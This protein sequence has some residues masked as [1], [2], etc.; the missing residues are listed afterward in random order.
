MSDSRVKYERI[1]SAAVLTINR[2]ERR[3]AID[4]ETAALLEQRFE[5]FC[6]DDT[7]L[8]LIVAG[9]GGQAFCAGADLK[10]VETLIPRLEGVGGP[11]GFSRLHSPKP[12]IAAVSG[13][14][15][16]GGFELALWCDIRIA[17]AESK[18]GFTERRFGVPLV[19][20]G[21]QRLPRVVGAGVAL[22]LTLSGRVVD[23]EEAHRIGLANELVAEGQHLTRALEY[24]EM[25]ATFPRRTM[26]AD[27][28]ALY[29]G[30]DLPLDEGLAFEARSGA[31]TL[32]DAAA[33]AARFASGEGRSANPL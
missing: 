4:G 31:A 19:D 7:A 15:L 2:P 10:A 27:R 5:Q 29:T 18:F 13:W 11:I 12:T 16:A 8:T 9:A 26:L 23:A 14:C 30:M 25:L 28:E 22:D 33:G 3:N 1:D 24:A 17:T 20:G 32:E 6:A 21:T